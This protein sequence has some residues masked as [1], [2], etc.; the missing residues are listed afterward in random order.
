MLL[1]DGSQSRQFQMRRPLG[2]NR[3]GLTVS[4]IRPDYP[5]QQTFSDQL[6]GPFRANFGSG[7]S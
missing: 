6:L 1:T 5:G 7:P 4:Q 2:V 3:V